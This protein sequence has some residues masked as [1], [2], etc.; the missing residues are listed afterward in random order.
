M[1]VL[2]ATCLLL[3]GVAHAGSFEELRVPS[4]TGCPGEEQQRLASSIRRARQALGAARASARA[5]VAG[6]ELED[7]PRLIEALRSA[8]GQTPPTEWSRATGCRSVFCALQRTLQSEG[9]AANWIAIAVGFGAPP[10]L[11]QAGLAK[12]SLWKESELHS[13]AATLFDLPPGLHRVP[14]VALVKRIPDGEDPFHGANAFSTRREKGLT[15]G[16][17]WFRDTAFRMPVRQLREIVAHELGHQVEFT[18]ATAQN[19]YPLS[20]GAEWLATSGWQLVGDAQKKDG[21]RLPPGQ[22][23]VSTGRPPLAS[24]DFADSVAGHR[25]TP[26][27]LASYS[28]QKALYLQRLL[29]ANPT[30]DSDGE[31]DAALASIGGPLAALRA[32]TSMI[33]GASRAADAPQATLQ[34][35]GKGG[36][37]SQV[38]RGFFLTRSSCVDDTLARLEATPAGQRLACRLE[39]EERYVA[40][41]DRLEVAWGAFAEAAARIHAVAAREAPRC[42]A[43][44]EL[45]VGCFTQGMATPRAE[46]QRILSELRG[47]PGDV[48][49]LAEE[50]ARQSVLLPPLEEIVALRPELG[51][52][53]QLVA[54]CLASTIEV[55]SE[56]GKTNWR[57]WIRQPPKN[58]IRGFAD[59]L[60]LP[61][62][63]TALAA[64][65][66][67]SRGL[68]V[69]PGDPAFVAV[70]SALRPAAA[71]LAQAF[72]S[73]VLGGWEA[74]RSACRVP[75][76]TKPIPA[77]QACVVAWL[78]P[79]LERLVPASE[80]DPTAATLAS[81]LRGP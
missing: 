43:K 27:L 6:L 45:S 2:V 55:S 60:A 32:C 75:P 9:A 25:Y 30:H 1:R 11:D 29:G 52:A 68:R 36:R 61:S 44:G 28:R 3:S 58:D 66:G 80:L 47:A 77:Q 17:I 10:S 33:V 18:R 26:R 65:L 42:L 5:T 54:A 38:A 22:D 70:S 37:T 7:D 39:R 8:L 62:C 24:E 20:H 21:Y 74:L 34:L 19:A 59:L 73:D 64:Q 69:V 57:F 71:P 50:L 49:A 79:R 48:D 13:V 56:P 46:A 53:K 4:P 31:V 35:L 81:K 76:A 63:A 16:A 40:V 78:R 41:A 12:P 23:L 72:A 67:R 15:R 14:N 51:D